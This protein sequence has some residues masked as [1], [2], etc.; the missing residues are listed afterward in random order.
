MEENT[1]DAMR[2]QFGKEETDE[3]LRLAKAIRS[4]MWVWEQYVDAAPRS[5]AESMAGERF[6]SMITDAKVSPEHAG[7]LIEGLVALVMHL[8]RGGD[9][10]VWFESLGIDSTPGPGEQP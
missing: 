1:L 8:R 2:A 10:D 9:Y 7:A 3:Y 4:L 6:K 5:L